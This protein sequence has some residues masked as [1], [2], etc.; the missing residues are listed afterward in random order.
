MTDDEKFFAWI[1]GELG[2]AEAA[3]ME[4]RVATDP[5][6]KRLAE[7]HRSLGAQMRSAFD[8]IATAPIPDRLQAALRPSAQVID[9]ALAK[10]TRSMPALA[11][12][13]AM[14]ATLAIGILVGTRLP[15]NSETPVQVQGGKLYAAA[16]L[17]S[18]L[19]T[20][21]ASAPSGDVNAH[22]QTA[23]EFRKPPR[24]HCKANGNTRDIPSWLARNSR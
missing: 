22:R 14:A 21:L 1:D 8:P 10:R 13:A 9:F 18:A 4:A 12:W 11:Q 6:L 19:D 2:A 7:Q 23:D 17:N 20:Q 5:D 3:E 15:E 24:L 16:A